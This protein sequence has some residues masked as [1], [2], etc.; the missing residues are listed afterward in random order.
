MEY[1]PL[2]NLQ[3]QHRVSPITIEETVT[4]LS[5]GLEA[6]DYLNSIDLAHRDIKPA[7]ILVQSRQPFSIKLA[8][9]GLAKDI[10]A[11][12]TRC[13]SYLYAAP[14]VFR[15]DPYTANVDVWSLGVVIFQYGYGL[16]RSESKFTTARWY[17]QLARE[18]EQ[19][20]RAVEDGD[21]DNLI[22]FLSENMLK[23][24]PEQRLSAGECLDRQNALLLSR[25]PLGTTRLSP[26]TE[27][28][29]PTLTEK[30]STSELLNALRT[31][32]SLEAPE[33]EQA[34]T[35]LWDPPHL[36]GTQAP[37]GDLHEPEQDE[38]RGSNVGSSVRSSVEEGSRR[39]LK[40]PHDET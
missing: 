31:R 18:V 32:E 40:R 26:D 13:G 30:V 1:L 21:S 38:L 16:P 33:P 12:L 29:D 5:Q 6:L 22:D 39:Q 25:G 15:G 10:S 36:H 28:E 3:E 20:A 35:Q 4:L 34:L 11:L 27:A 23:E 37:A 17:A 2:G 8:D 14:E 9:F 7:N 24:D 19:L